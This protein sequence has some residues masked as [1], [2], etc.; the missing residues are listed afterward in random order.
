MIMGHPVTW[1]EVQ[2]F[3]SLAST[4]YLLTGRNPTD[5]EIGEMVGVARQL[6]AGALLRPGQTGALWLS[7]PPSPL[8]RA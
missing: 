8:P 3:A 4:H 5:A 6:T 1:D 7:A 2:C